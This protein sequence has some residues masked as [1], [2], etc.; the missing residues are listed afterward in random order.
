MKQSLINLKDKL[1]KAGFKFEASTSVYNPMERFADYVSTK[2]IV[3]SKIIAD[4][5]N[6]KGEHQLGYGFL[7]KFLHAIGIELITEQNPDAI[8]PLCNI[9][10]DTEFF[11]PTDNSN[12]R[13]DILLRVELANKKKYAIIIENKLNDAPDQFRQLKRYNAYVEKKM[14]YTA[15]ER[16][17]VYMP[18]IGGECKDYPT[19]KVINASTLA[20]IIDETLEESVSPNIASIKAYA[21]YLRNIS[22]NNII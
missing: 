22:I 19:A 9:L 7:V 14:G 8:N 4:L 10:V 18:R 13:I 17:T 2:E 1:K 21:N 12:G 3:H 6:P 16:I 20:K 5:L 11:A 15:D